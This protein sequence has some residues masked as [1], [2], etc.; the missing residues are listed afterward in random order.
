MNKLNYFLGF[1]FLLIIFLL[2][3]DNHY[4][5]DHLE[6][7]FWWTGMTTDKLQLM[8][9]GS[10]INELKPSISYPGISIHAIPTSNSNYLFI[11]R[12]K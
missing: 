6:P 10:D 8:V 2:T 7:P 9:H 11:D 3:G 12:N 1:C 4:A 5:I